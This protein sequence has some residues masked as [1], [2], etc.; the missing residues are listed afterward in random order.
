[1][2]FFAGASNVTILGGSFVNNEVKGNITIDD[3][4]RHTSYLNSNNKSTNNV[5]NSHN[6][7]S[8]RISEQFDWFALKGRLMI[9]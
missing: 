4:S 8:T 7:N 2:A 1:M 6:D 9:Y 3:H 5:I